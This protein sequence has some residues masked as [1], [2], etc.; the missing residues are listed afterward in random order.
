MSVQETISLLDF[1]LKIKPTNVAPGNKLF[2]PEAQKDAN[3]SG[4]ET[5]VM[6]GLTI[7]EV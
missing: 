5:S 6:V 1:N 3:L 2:L 4:K 7:L